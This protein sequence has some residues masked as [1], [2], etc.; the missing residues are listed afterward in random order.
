MEQWWHRLAEPVA[1]KWA[2]TL[3]EFIKKMLRDV[4]T[5]DWEEL[6]TGPRSCTGSTPSW[7]ASGNRARPHPD[8]A[9]LAAA[10]PGQAADGNGLRRG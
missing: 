5:G 6:A 3:D 4:S 2:S 10:E 7:N 8:D 1:K 9:Q